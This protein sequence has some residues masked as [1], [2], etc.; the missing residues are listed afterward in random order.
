MADQA[1]VELYLQVVETKKAE[2]AKAQKPGYTTNLTYPLTKGESVNLAAI[3]DIG[4]LVQIL[5][6]LLMKSKFH[7]EASTILGVESEFKIGVNSLYTVNE[8]T[9]DIKTRIL[10]LN[11][12]KNKEILEKLEAELLKMESAEVKEKKKMSEIENLLKG[13]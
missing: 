13:L 9:E 12:R 4:Q 1:K 8:W 11:L 2:I 10:V 7:K 3:T 5:S 6:D